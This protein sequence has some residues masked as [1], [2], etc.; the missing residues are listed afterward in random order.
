MDAQQINANTLILLSTV[1]YFVERVLRYALRRWDPR[2]SNFLHQTRKDACF[3]GISMGLLISLLSTPSCARGAW[4]AWSALGASPPAPW[5][6]DEDVQTCVTA[7]AVLWIS[8]LNRLDMY[9]LYVVHHAGAL[10]S[11][12]SF[13]YLQWP[14]L[15]VI[16]VFATLVSEIP[17]D[18]L[19]MLSAYIESLD[20]D[21][22]SP[23]TGTATLPTQLHTLKHRLTV[24]NALQ[25]ALVRG[26]GILFLL[27]LILSNAFPEVTLRTRSAA[28]QLEA[29]SL[30]ILYTAFCAAYVVRQYRSI[31]GHR[32]AAAF[33]RRS[34]SVLYSEKFVQ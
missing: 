8:E 34:H 16:A 11:L 25:Y 5:S 24:F 29:Y 1:Y 27:W 7:R 10:L 4:N 21:A 31:Q 28:V 32:R 18:F 23:T 9:T 2:F 20:A 3:F 17:G 14:V 30:G 22:P 6:L 26:A 15:P 13:L 12:L 19:W 33:A